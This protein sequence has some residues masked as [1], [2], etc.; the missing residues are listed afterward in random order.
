M[1]D[2]Y[3]RRLGDA[4]YFSVR[5]DPLLDIVHSPLNT[6][7]QA[8]ASIIGLT[9]PPGDSTPFLEVRRVTA[10]QA[11]HGHRGGIRTSTFEPSWLSVEPTERVTPVDAVEAVARQVAAVGTRPT[12]LLSGGWDSRLLAIIARHRWRRIRA[13]T[14]S[15]DDGHDYDI[16]IAQ[17]VADTLKLKH[18]IFVPGAE[19]W[20]DEH[21]TVYRRLEF[22]TTHHIWFMPLV[23][24]IHRRDRLLVDGLAGD[25]LFKS[26]FVTLDVAETTDSSLRWRKLWDHLEQRRVRQR[27]L[28]APGVS[29]T[30]EAMS[31]EAFGSV[32]RRF[33]GHPAAATL[34]VLHTR[35]ARAI[36]SSPQWLLGP[37]VEVRVPFV[38]PEVITTALQVPVRLKAGG[39]FYRQMLRSASPVAA[40]LPSTNDSSPR[41]RRGHVR[42]SSS[43]ALQAMVRPI[44]ADEG[45]LRLLSPELRL[46]L[47]RP[48]MLAVIARST[49]GLRLLQG[50]NLLGEW[51]TTYAA[52]LADNGF[53]PS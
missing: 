45:T 51:R 49:R 38:H 43:D 21:V 20:R 3:Y 26:L 52:K 35:T 46:A 27:D 42:Q 53:D 13:W 14:T 8:W 34:S 23:R 11:W 2:L 16:A 18:R 1:Q 4:L 9:F 37:E 28:L 15:N 12:V 29:S 6:D 41:G 22:Q 5:I 31:R 40:S 48:D 7:W 19:A 24:Q 39:E 33:D 36:A 30:L 32:V 50:M 47:S 44:L 10:A 25:V 17:R